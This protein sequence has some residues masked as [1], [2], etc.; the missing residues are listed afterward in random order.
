MKNITPEKD[1]VKIQKHFVSTSTV[2]SE[3]ENGLLILLGLLELLITNRRAFFCL[4]M[5]VDEMLTLLNAMKNE[6]K[7]V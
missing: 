6:I 7:S 3:L 2:S 5:D 1:M 4:L